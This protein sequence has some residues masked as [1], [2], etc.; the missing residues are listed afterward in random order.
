MTASLAVMLCGCTVGPDFQPP[1]A[2]VP[3]T[4]LDG[5]RVTPAKVASHAVATPIDTAWWAVFHDPVLTALVQRGAAANLDVRIAAIRLAESR[6]QRAVAGAAQ[7]PTLGA[8]ASYTRELAS[9]NGLMSLFGASSGAAGA[10][11]N[12]TGSGVT[13]VSSTATKSGGSTPLGLSQYGLDAS[14]ELDLWGRVRRSIESADAS[15]QLSQEAQRAA[16]ISTIAEIARDYVALRGTQTTLRIT[17]ENLDTAQ[18]VLDLTRQRNQAGL[19]TDLDVIDASAQIATIQSQIPPLE[20][21]VEAGI[22][23]LSFLV[24]EAPGNLRS[25]LNGSD[26]I[27]PAPPQVPVG[28]PSELARR[29]PDIRQA[30]A[31]LHQATAAIGMA[32]ADFYPQI[33]LSGSA[34]VQALEFTNLGSWNSRQYSFGPTITLPIFEGGR[35]RGTLALREAQQQEA[36]VS[37]QRTVLQAWHEIDDALTAF[38]TEQQR[39]DQLRE[40]AAQNRE[41]VVLARQRYTQG[42]AGFLRVL[43]AERNRLATEQQLASSTTTIST[44]LVTLYKALGGGWQ[45]TIPLTAPSPPEL[46]E[47]RS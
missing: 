22:N 24:G 35:L 20:Q 2:A 14:W 42:V 47:P 37:Y 5:S 40:A 9:N 7:F 3:A 46:R 44:N 29:R 33:T 26:V 25:E 15:V 43:D 18:Q 30:E 28:L 17:R 23:Q 45:D 36:A 12:G 10:A 11:A 6:S 31:E 39:H 16:L 19:V 13:T 38:T 41:A 1:S 34:G 4:W 21:Q 32:E 8:N 27:P